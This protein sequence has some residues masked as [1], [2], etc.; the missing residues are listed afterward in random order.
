[1]TDFKTSDRDVDRAIRS[2][3]HQER[4]EDASRLAGA[5]LDQLDT[6]PQRR[7]TWWP[8]WR[9]PSMKRFVTIGIGAAAVVVLLFVGARFLGSPSGGVGG[10]SEPTATPGASFAGEWRRVADA[11]EALTEV[12]VAAHDG[13][14]WVA[15]GLDAAEEVVDTVWLFD[16]QADEWSSGP[17]L[18]TPVHHAVLVSTGEDLLLIGGYLGSEFGSLTNAVWRLT[19]DRTGWDEDVPLPSP[20]AA[21]AAAWDGSRVVYG[22]GVTPGGATTDIIALADGEW[23]RVAAL[24]SPREHL[25]AA[26]DG[27]G[28]TWFLGGRVGPLNT[29]LRSAFLVEGDSATNL[30]DVL[31]PRGGV[32]GFYAP[33]IGACSVGGEEPEG[34]F[35]TVEC[36]D[37]DGEVTTLPPLTVARHGTGAAVLDGVAYAVVGGTEPAGS[38]SSVVEALDLPL[39]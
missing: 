1:M 39:E 11:P 34:T 13:R 32:S 33:G 20:T 22:G 25:A 27:D 31:T 18:P 3:L 30:G 21:G 19:D 5:V 36:V 38:G 10:P 37:A 14:I 29:N 35:D 7:A 15:G 26:S 6:T 4:H 17:P 12:A 2:W 24:W 9:T 23:N 16:P 28:R 8:A